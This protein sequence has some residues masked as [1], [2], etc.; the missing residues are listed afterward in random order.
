M[1]RT[2]TILVVCALLLLA[3]GIY[4]G[5]RSDS[6]AIA[7]NDQEQHA[8]N[9]RAKLVEPTASPAAPH[10]VSESAQ[11]SS[12]IGPIASPMRQSQARAQSNAR[13]E[14]SS[15]ASPSELTPASKAIEDWLTAPGDPVMGNPLAAPHQVFQAEQADTQ[16]SPAA[17]QTLKDR[18]GDE[19][20]SK[21]EFPGIECRADMCE[22]QAATLTA[23][24]GDDAM[25][26]QRSIYQMPQSDWWKNAGFGPPTFAVKGLPDGRDVVI[27]FVSRAP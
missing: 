14:R 6:T 24:R 22:I 20:G 21:L 4:I 7:A 2:A 25:A 11:T 19:F 15:R 26:L 5:S 18:L 9:D 8:V 13:G 12:L 3:G 10:T 17:T 1:R 23:G 27:I 16:W